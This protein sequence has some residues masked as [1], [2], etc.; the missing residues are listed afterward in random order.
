MERGG[1]GKFK[2]FF[3]QSLRNRNHVVFLNPVTT[4]RTERDSLIPKV[5][6]HKRAMYVFWYSLK[7]TAFSVS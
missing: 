6:N 2:V 4:H 3:P 1:K 7:N 5:R